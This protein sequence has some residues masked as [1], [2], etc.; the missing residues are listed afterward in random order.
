MRERLRSIAQRY[1]VRVMRPAR[2]KALASF[3]RRTMTPEYYLSIRRNFGMR[4]KSLSPGLSLSSDLELRPFEKRSV[5][6]LSMPISGKVGPLYIGGRSHS[7]FADLKRIVG[8]L[9]VSAVI[10]CA[11]QGR[12]RTLETSVRETAANA[13]DDLKVTWCLVGSVPADADF[14]KE[15]T[16]AHSNVV[17]LM[18]PDQAAGWR[19]QA[20]VDLARRVCDFELLA[21]TGSD[22]VLS[23]GLVEGILARY[24]GYVEN[25]PRG[26]LAPGLYATMQWLVLGSDSEKVGGP[27]VVKCNYR[28]GKSGVPFGAGRFY[29]R[30]M[31][32]GCDGNIFDPSS[33]RNLNEKGFYQTAA[34]GMGI[35]YYTL[36][37]GAVISV[38]RQSAQLVESAAGSDASGVEVAE[39]TF[40]AST[41]LRRQLAATSLSELLKITSGS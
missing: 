5:P 28:T 27:Y 1:V 12:H 17:G 10:C 39:F 36:A 31:I 16:A 33:G 2:I 18:L 4:L 41:I 25:D 22:E 3:M 14:L 8:D 30:T 11:F 13:T 38:R 35:D 26:T 34:M 29:S 9:S 24:R 6:D 15:L 21:I 23:R 37:D 40:E 7:E 32:D 19:W 20:A